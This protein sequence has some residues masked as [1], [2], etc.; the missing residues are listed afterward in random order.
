M[1]DSEEEDEEVEVEDNPNDKASIARSRL[2]QQQQQAAAAISAN[3]K[4]RSSAFDTVGDLFGSTWN[5]GT[6]V[7]SSVV[8]LTGFDTTNFTSTSTSTSRRKVNKVI[9]VKVEL[10]LDSP[11]RLPELPNLKMVLTSLSICLSVSLSVSNYVFI[12]FDCITFS[13]YCLLVF[14][15]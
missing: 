13:I 3:Q 9:K 6:S 10:P 1:I 5:L 15:C 7:T 12:I 2:P 11:H 14:T 4:R 8:G